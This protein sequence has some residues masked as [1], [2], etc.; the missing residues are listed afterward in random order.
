M[1]KLACHESIQPPTRRESRAGRVQ[2]GWWFW[3]SFFQ[4]SLNVHRVSFITATI[5][6]R[7]KSATNL[8]PLWYGSYSENDWV[9]KFVRDW[10]GHLHVW[11]L[12]S[13]TFRTGTFL[14]NLT[15]ISPGFWIHG[16]PSFCIGACPS[17]RIV[18]EA[19][20]PNRCG[21]D[22]PTWNQS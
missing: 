18:T 22:N 7:L 5:I 14:W 12:P 19:A 6:L 11:L 4:Y 13:T 21:S 15:L 10:V 1:E 20:W 17:R 2:C 9:N 8:T 16:S 3:C